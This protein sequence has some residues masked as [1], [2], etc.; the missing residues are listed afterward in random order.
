MFGPMPSS[1][2]ALLGLVGLAVML[3]TVACTANI[4][5][6]SSEPTASSGAGGASLGSG[7]AGG[8]GAAAPI[9]PQTGIPISCDGAAKLA[10]PSPS[11]RLTNRE[12]RN[13]LGDLFPG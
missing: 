4:E 7:A 3:G 6:N 8:T 11:L 13:T 2:P 12:Y 5:R 1:S 9:D 10:A